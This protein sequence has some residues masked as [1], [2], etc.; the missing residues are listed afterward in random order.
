MEKG[1]QISATSGHKLFDPQRPVIVCRPFSLPKKIAS[2][3][4]VLGQT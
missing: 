4:F 1:E 3:V 2:H